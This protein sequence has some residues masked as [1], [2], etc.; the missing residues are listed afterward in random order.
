[1]P[2]EWVPIA[3]P[4][5]GLIAL[6]VWLVR[7]IASGVLVSGNQVERMLHAQQETIDRQS[8][9]IDRLIDAGQVATRALDALPTPP[10]E[11]STQ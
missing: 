6:L 3:T 8:D 7:A 9:Q 11:G 5:A 10:A 4:T 1:M 2:V